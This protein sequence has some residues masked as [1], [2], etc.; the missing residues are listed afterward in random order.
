M[1]PAVSRLTTSDPPVRHLNNQLVSVSC[2]GVDSRSPRHAT[3]AFA[4]LVEIALKVAE[5]R[6]GG[7]GEFAD[8]SNPAVYSREQHVGSQHV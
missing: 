4:I 5:D 1:K 8:D 7:V 3:W 2:A 6:A